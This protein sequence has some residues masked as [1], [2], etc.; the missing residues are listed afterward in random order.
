MPAGADKHHGSVNRYTISSAFTK[1]V[2]KIIKNY[3]SNGLELKLIEK[4]LGDLKMKPADIPIEYYSYTHRVGY[5]IVKEYKKSL[6]F[7]YGCPA[8][9]PC[10]FTLV[11][12]YNG[13]KLNQFPELIY[14]HNTQL[15]YD[16]I[17][18]FSSPNTLTLYFIET[19]KKHKISI[20]RKYFNAVIP[21]YQFD[22][23]ILKNNIVTLTYNS[24]ELDTT[25]KIIIDLKKYRH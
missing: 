1:E 14:N 4:G 10:M 11:D 18:Y 25:G 5:D 2:S 3:I 12:K 9:G 24:N 16:F 13:K 6:L 23:V 7:R 22:D 21:E 8:N 20:N 17:I 19:N 15:F